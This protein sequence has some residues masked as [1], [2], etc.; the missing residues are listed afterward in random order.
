MAKPLSR[1]SA[2]SNN[3]SHGSHNAIATPCCPIQFHRIKYEEEEATA[4]EEEEEEEETT[5][6]E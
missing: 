6:E 2:M 1:H 3:S 5:A 4:E